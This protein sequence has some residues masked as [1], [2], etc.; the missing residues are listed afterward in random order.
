MIKATKKQA[1][2]LAEIGLT[3]K[4]LNNQ[5]S[6]LKIEDIATI[7]GVNKGGC[8]SGAFMPAVTYYDAKQHMAIHGDAILDYIRDTFGAIPAHE[9]DFWGSVCT[10]Y[11][12]LAVETWCT[13]FDLEDVDWD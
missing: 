12:S 13:Q 1:E 4:D 8:M 6:W 11:Y 10:F 5:P 2:Q 7:Q 9:K 3:V